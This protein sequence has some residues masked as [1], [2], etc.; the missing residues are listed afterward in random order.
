[1]GDIQ[2]AKV[3]TWEKAGYL[4]F[5]GSLFPALIISDVF[6]ALGFEFWGRVALTGLVCL[7]VGYLVSR[8][9][10]AGRSRRL[11]SDL[12]RGIFDC[13]I[14]YP[15]SH[16]GSLRDRW[17][18]GVAQLVAGKL[19]FQPQNSPTDPSPMP[20]GAPRELGIDKVEGVIAT[21]GRRPVELRRGWKV[22]AVD[23]PSG[24]MHLAAGD[25]AVELLREEFRG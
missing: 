7:G 22:L 13:A 4:L 2:R 24:K 10:A 3:G 1:M 9:A 11:A 15:D 6:E 12:S 23:T 17:N 21:E 8:P 25:P 19:R 20:L 5:F 14:R 16:P 18:P